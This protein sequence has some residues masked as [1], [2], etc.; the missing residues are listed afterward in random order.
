LYASNIKIVT[1][2][3]V[4]W[5]TTLFQRHAVCRLSR[6]QGSWT[7]SN[8]PVAPRRELATTVSRI[9]LTDNGVDE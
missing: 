3:H 5:C 9:W 2:C 7:E 8:S 6:I 4:S 1:R